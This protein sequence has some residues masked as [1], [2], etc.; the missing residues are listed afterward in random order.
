MFESEGIKAYKVE[1]H[2]L[3]RISPQTIVMSVII[4]IPTRKPLHKPI[5][6]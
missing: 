6:T 4:V 5:S 1:A 2:P 3:F